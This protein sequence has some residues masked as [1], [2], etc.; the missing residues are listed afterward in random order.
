MSSKNTM[1]LEVDW[2]GEKTDPGWDLVAAEIPDIAKTLVGRS[3]ALEHVGVAGILQK[4]GPQGLTTDAADALQKVGGT[5][6]AIGRVISAK[7]TTAVVELDER[8]PHFAELV[9]THGMGVSLTHARDPVTNAVTAL[10]LSL[11]SEPMR[12]NARVLSYLERSYL[13]SPLRYASGA[14]RNMAEQ[15]T[16]M[17]TEAA[18]ATPAA[19]PAETQV[20]PLEAAL[21]KLSES[22]RRL[23]EDRFLEYEKQRTESTAGLAAAD[24]KM[25]EMKKL[26][27]TKNTDAQ[28][29]RQKF[30]D[31]V[32]SVKKSDA[33]LGSS[34][35]SCAS[36][37]NSDDS[38]M[39]A[40]AL[41][42]VVTVCSAFFH[43][44]SCFG[45]QQQRNPKRKIEE[46]ATRAAPAAAPRA[47]VSDAVFAGSDDRCALIILSGGLQ[48]GLQ[49]NGCLT[50]LFNRSKSLRNALAL[51][52]L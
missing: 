42:R 16:P 3:V 48:Q 21:S 28:L 43:K 15:T 6:G 18:P 2:S 17:Q 45:E 38:A 11:C 32:A 34:L 35:E 12:P 49:R 33:D 40:Y 10:E 25:A 51:N 26:L 14:A 22:D 30:D 5:R 52:F 39:N 8:Y 1:L 24:S 27:E 19:A 46:V 37:V 7:G 29:L 20:S 13:P 23:L 9:K 44:Q 31:L 50:P 47:P 4:Q 36:A 41:D